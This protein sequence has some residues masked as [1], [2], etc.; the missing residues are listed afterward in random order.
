MVQTPLE[1]VLHYEGR[2]INQHPGPLD[3]DPVRQLDFGGTGMYGRRVHCARLL[4]LRLGKSLPEDMWTEV[5]AQRVAKQY[6]QGALLGIRTVPIELDDDPES[7]A[8]RALPEE[9]QLQID[10]LAAFADGNVQEYCRPQP[11]ISDRHVSLLLEA[12]RLAKLIF[13]KG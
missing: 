3:P 2:S 5:S 11:L 13:P 6:D 4:F 7:L 8:A 12:K 10:T 1:V 9:H